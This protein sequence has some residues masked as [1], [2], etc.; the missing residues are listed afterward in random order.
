MSENWMESL[1]PG[2]RVV[3]SRSQYGSVHKYLVTVEST[4]PTLV[5]T[6]GYEF[7]KKDGSRRGR[8]T[9]AHGPYVRI[10]PVTPEN[11][12][13]V[14]REEMRRAI[15]GPTFNKDMPFEYVEIIHAAMV[16]CGL[17]KEIAP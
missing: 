10:L 5:R 15:N 6:N 1:K 3:M 16:K 8:H 17:L 14:R 11:K 4:T 13:D 12:E 2:D 9:T 7:Y